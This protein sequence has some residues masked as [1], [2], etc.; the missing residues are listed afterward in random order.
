MPT[1]NKSRAKKSWREKLLD[2]KDLPKVEKITGRMQKT[3]GKGTLVIPAPRQVDAIMAKARKGKLL[4]IN[5]I[6]AALAKE[7]KA[8]TACPI[9]TGIFAWIAANAAQEA[10]EAGAKKVTPYWRTLKGQNEI[11][12]KYPGGL[13]VQKALLESEGHQVIAKG[14]RM[15]VVDADKK[16]MQLL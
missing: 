16:M 13:E 6:R 3:C 15:L 12:P 1:S 5:T 11:N 8:T 4:N 7:N 14:K 2:D 9:C 10:I